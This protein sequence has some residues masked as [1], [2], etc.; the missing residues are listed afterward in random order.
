MKLNLSVI[1]EYISDGNYDFL[2][3]SFFIKRQDLQGEIVL[4]L[5]PRAD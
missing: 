4:F 2:Q 1:N 3:L 5:R